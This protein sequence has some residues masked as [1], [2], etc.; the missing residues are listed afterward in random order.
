MLPC[1]RVTCFICGLFLLSVN[2]IAQVVLS[3]VM[4]N[5]AGSEYHDEYVELFNSSASNAIDIS[6]W[7]ISDSSGSDKISAGTSPVILK[8]QQFAIILDGSYPGNSTTYDEIIPESAL[9]LFLD[10]TTFGSNGFSN[11]K[12]EPVLLIDAAGDTVQRYRYS[13]DNKEGYSDEK[14][15][16]TGDNASANWANSYFPGGT[17]GYRN[18][19]TPFPLD[20]ALKN[21]ALSYHPALFITVGQT[22]HFNGSIYNSGENRFSDSLHVFFYDDLD[23]DGLWQEPE[24][25]VFNAI[26]FA[27]VEPGAYLE[28]SMQWTP[29]QA[30][31][32]NLVLQIESPSDANPA[33]N[34]YDLPL[35]VY[36][37]SET[38]AL[39]EINFLASGPEPEWVEICN[40]G[41][42]KL[43]LL[44]WQIADSRDT[45]RIDSTIFLYPG[46]LKVFGPTLSEE[47]SAPLVADSLFIPLE[48]F[49]TLNNSE[50]DIY[51]LNPGSGWVE[52][53]PYTEDW[54]EGEAWRKPS[55]ERI[56]T[57]LDCRRANSWGPCTE[58]EGSTPARQNSIYTELH[59]QS[60]AR[61]H[62]E[63][64]PFSPDGDGKDD[65]TLIELKSP[66]P[67][68]RLRVRIYDINGHCVRRIM[69][70]AFTGKQITI[71]WDGREDNGQ[72][73]PVGIYVI[74][75]EWLDDKN[76]VYQSSKQTVVLAARL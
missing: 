18:S 55:L 3:E 11:S 15:R 72:Q 69:E 67:A 62:C 56:N 32:Y 33:N 57:K 12:P 54:L 68:A 28:F 48:G 7:I 38:V 8:P 34:R 40:T 46:Q 73:L 59:A 70:N 29:N 27:E 19:V 76:G 50:D 66:T 44:G 13:I 39:N 37:A 58:S 51:L 20:L 43:N 52:Q 4:F 49:P 14:I 60:R 30:Q 42:T 23:R 17:P 47:Q 74:L 5:P 16:L 63:P 24:L 65:Y 64:N 36:D 35:Q 31:F 26:L 10:G 41:P 45:A 61:V 71:S 21:D 2:A 75:A 6:N 53:V 25:V 1:I 9:L 22:V